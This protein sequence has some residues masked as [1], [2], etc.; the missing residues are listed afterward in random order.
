MLAVI[1]DIE[2]CDKRVIDELAPQ[3]LRRQ[4]IPIVTMS[5]ASGRNEPDVEDDESPRDAPESEKDEM[6]PLVFVHCDEAVREC[7][8]CLDSQG[9]TA[10][11]PDFDATLPITGGFGTICGTPVPA[12]CEPP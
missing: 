3:C 9:H 12:A 11:S 10:T 6:A 2:Y 8:P 7:T 4:F 5:F 1:L